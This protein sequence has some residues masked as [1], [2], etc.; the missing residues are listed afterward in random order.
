MA[1]RAKHYRKDVS[2]WPAKY[3]RLAIP[4]LPDSPHNLSSEFRSFWLSIRPC[5]PYI[6]NRAWGIFRASDITIF[7]PTSGQIAWQ[8]PDP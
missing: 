2:C 4:L 5:W 1:D 6:L 3:G 7:R 8:P